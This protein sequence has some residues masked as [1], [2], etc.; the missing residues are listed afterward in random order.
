[1]RYIFI[2]LICATTIHANPRFLALRVNAAGVVQGYHGTSDPAPP[3][4]MAIIPWVDLSR[5]DLVPKPGKRRSVNHY[6]LTGTTLQRRPDADVDADDRAE[7]MKDAKSDLRA[8]TRQRRDLAEDVK[9]G[10]AELGELNAL[11]A[12]ITAKRIEIQSLR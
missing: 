6:R 4:G 3:D 1:M 2:V 9:T 5:A 12:K 7:R 10:D 11:D 8:L